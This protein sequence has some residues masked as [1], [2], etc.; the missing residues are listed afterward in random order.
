MIALLHP[1]HVAHFDQTTMMAAY[2]KELVIYR[3]WDD[4]YDVEWVFDTNEDGWQREMPLNERVN[5]FYVL[6]NRK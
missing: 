2:F 5:L 4:L 6:E 1:K 3:M